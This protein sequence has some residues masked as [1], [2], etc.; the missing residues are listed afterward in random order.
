MD[1]E[2]SLNTILKEHMTLLAKT[3]RE[4]QTVPAESNRCD[5]SRIVFVLKF[6]VLDS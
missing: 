1:A 3:A 6:A 2:F 4:G 5:A